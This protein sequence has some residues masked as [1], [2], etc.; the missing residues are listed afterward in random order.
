[1]N[2]ISL[3]VGFTLNKYVVVIDLPNKSFPGVGFS[4]YIGL[5]SLTLESLTPLAVV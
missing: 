1:M 5:S 2:C 3:A 4:P